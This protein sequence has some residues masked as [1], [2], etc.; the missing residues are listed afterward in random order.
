M[1]YKPQIKKLDYYLSDSESDPRYV[2]V[3]G[4]TMTG[5]LNLTGS[6]TQILFPDNSD[7]TGGLLFGGDTNLYRSAANVLKTDDRFDFGAGLRVVNTGSTGNLEIDWASDII[8]IFSTAS[9]VLRIGDGG[10]YLIFDPA[11]ASGGPKF[12]YDRVS[13]TSGSL[14]RVTSSGGLTGGAGITQYGF[15]VDPIVNQ[16]STATFVG[17]DILPTYTAGGSNAIGLRISTP[18]GATN[19]YALQLSGTG[20]TAASGIT[21]GTDT[22]LYRS[23]TSTLRTLANLAVGDGTAGRGISVQSTSFSGFTF[24]IYSDSASAYS[25]MRRTRGSVGSPTV[26]TSGSFLGS[27]GFRGYADAGMPNQDAARISSYATQTFSTTHGAAIGFYTA[28]NGTL[29]SAG[30]S[31]R[32]TIYHDGNIG[33]GVTAPTAKL[34]FAVATTAAG[35]ILFGTDTNLYRS[36][37]DTLA[38]DDLFLAAGGIKTNNSDQIANLFINSGS[39]LTSTTQATL[40]I[41]GATTTQ[42]RALVRGAAGSLA[43]G[44]AYASFLFGAVPIT[45]NGSGNHPLLSQAAFR[46]LNITGAGATVTDTATVYIEAAASTTVS[47]GNYA[48]WV[49]DG[50]TRLDGDLDHNGTN[51]GFYGVTHVARATTGIAEAAFVENAGGTAVNDDSTFGGYTIRQVVQAL[52]NIG[53]LT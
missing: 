29:V 47:G 11:S 2:N 39:G 40:Q 32:M 16:T 30:S 3:S 25:F 35:G 42:A 20:G 28:A 50:T 38:T 45:E 14:F 36:A 51:V 9:R 48:L 1:T 8:R 17:V 33:I 46:A 12:A 34:Q 22:E 15:R 43:N 19:N 31:E 21:F 13:A 10:G 6:G 52:Q 53:I 7:S 23:G 37:A 5:D 49:D 26:V 4:D 18:S 41:A 24:D 27:L 44:V